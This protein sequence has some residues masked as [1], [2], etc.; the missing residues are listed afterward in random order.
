[1]STAAAASDA[2]SAGASLGVLICSKDRAWQLSQLLASIEYAQADIPAERRA[3]MHIVVIYTH[4]SDAH[5]QSY[6]K[7][8]ARHSDVQFILESDPCDAAANDPVA[9]SGAAAAAPSVTAASSTPFIDHVFSTVGHWR[10]RGSGPRHLM[11]G[12]DDMLFF[13]GVPF[14]QLMEH[15][16]HDSQLLAVHLAPGQPVG[17][18]TDG[19]GGC[20]RRTRGRL[21]VPDEI[22]APPRRL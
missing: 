11:F 20:R 22:H 14:L 13:R 8:K 12:V 16:D 19:D 2:P 7:L 17:Q 15:M 4:S 9:S 6:A 5:A 10:S 18:E 21:A 1:M 3:T